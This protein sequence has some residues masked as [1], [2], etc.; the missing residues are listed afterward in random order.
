MATD[1][2]LEL[3]QKL[4]VTEGGQQRRVTKQRAILKALLAKSLRGDVR[5]ATALLRLIPDAELARHATAD[6]GT[7]TATDKDILQ[8]FREQ[9][10]AELGISSEG[11]SHG[12]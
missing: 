12:K 7:L 4:L 9:L 5:A 11:E 6:A 8:A 1:L 2:A 3:A 10:K